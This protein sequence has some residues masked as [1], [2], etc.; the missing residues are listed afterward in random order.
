MRS[1]IVAVV[2][3]VAVSAWSKDPLPITTCG[4]HVAKFQVGVLQSDITCPSSFVCR[5]ACSAMFPCDTGYTPT[6]LCTPDCS[7]PDHLCRSNECPNPATDFCQLPKDGDY[8]RGIQVE[9]GGEIDLNG[10][11]LSNAWLGIWSNGL[12]KH[13]G[14]VTVTG[15]GTI[16]GSQVAIGSGKVTATNLTLTGNA[17]GVSA[18]TFKLANVTIDGGTS[19]IFTTR[20]GR[21]ANVS[22]TGAS[23]GL[24]SLR[25]VR[26][27]DSTVTGNTTDVATART[28]RLLRST[29]DASAQLVPDPAQP[30]NY[31]TNGSTWGIC[32]ND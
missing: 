19:G 25:S 31:I 8:V 2:V 28:P 12:G 1:A 30:W 3:L 15:P 26:L 22:V 18:I 20:G 7:G 24:T 29:C 23:V 16:T 27:T 6:I 4:Q 11:T 5:P 10:H 17:W 9:P 14:K 32:T 13:Y 21:A